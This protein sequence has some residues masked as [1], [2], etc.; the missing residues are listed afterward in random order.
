M[1]RLRHSQ[2]TR[3]SSSRSSRSLLLSPNDAPKVM[4]TLQVR[5]RYPHESG[6][7]E[8][9]SGLEHRAAGG[10]LSLPLANTT[11]V[12]RENDDDSK[13]DRTMCSSSPKRWQQR[14]RRRMLQ[15]Y[16]HSEEQ[17]RRQQERRRERHQGPKPPPPSTTM[18]GMLNL[19]RWGFT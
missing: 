8:A 19:I 5:S 12:V 10:K 7:A 6:G 14:R 1:I 13:N 15:Y 2:I 17:Q 11:R 4:V 16:H 18:V 9:L 3:K